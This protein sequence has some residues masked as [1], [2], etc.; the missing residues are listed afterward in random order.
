MAAISAKVDGGAR[1]DEGNPR[2]LRLV[3]F[4]TLPQ[5][6]TLATAIV[7][8]GAE[9]DEGNPN[10]VYFGTLIYF[11]TLLDSSLSPFSDVCLYGARMY[12]FMFQ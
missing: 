12:V 1:V 3:Y 6:P 8:K 5:P 7:D 11:G 9:V 2:E 10:L 4:G